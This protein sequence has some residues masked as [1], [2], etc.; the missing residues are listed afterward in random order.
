M[1][2]SVRVREQE[3]NFLETRFYFEKL[4]GITNTYEKESYVKTNN[5]ITRIKFR[6]DAK[7]NMQRRVK[8]VLR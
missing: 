2:N 6:E 3:A 7:K 8:S 1:R 4:L 5:G